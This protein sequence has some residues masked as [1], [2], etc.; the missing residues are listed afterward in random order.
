MGYLWI[1]RSPMKLRFQR[2][3]NQVNRKCLQAG[4]AELPKVAHSE[5]FWTA[6]NSGNKTAIAPSFG[7]RLRWVSTRWKGN[8]IKF[9]MEQHFCICSVMYTGENP[10][11][12]GSST[13]WEQDS[14]DEDGDNK[15]KLGQCFHWTTRDVQKF[16]IKQR[17]QEHWQRR[18]KLATSDARICYKQITMDYTQMIASN[19]A[20]TLGSH[21]KDHGVIWRYLRHVWSPTNE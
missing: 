20:D 8:L 17:L 21:T 6:C 5:I 19:G 12:R 18:H 2:I 3:K 15:E 13:R 4:M 1:F 14:G 16:G 9:S 7:L 10:R 11:K